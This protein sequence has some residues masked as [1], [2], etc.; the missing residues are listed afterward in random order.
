MSGCAV[1][2]RNGQ[3]HTAW[4]SPSLGL[5]QLLH[6]HQFF[7]RSR[8]SSSLCLFIPCPATWSAQSPVSTLL[9]SSLH[10]SLLPCSSREE[11]HALEEVACR[12]WRVRSA[13]CSSIR[14]PVAACLS[15]NCGDTQLLG[16]RQRHP[17]PR[18]GSRAATGPT[19]PTLQTVLSS[20]SVRGALRLRG[21][22]VFVS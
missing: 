3:E 4:G 16:E 21:A 14:A 2:L 1:P 10:V 6:K 5:C 9:G 22:L 7:K 19:A 8:R 18:V 11:L 20:C 15:L 12:V 17:C 13:C